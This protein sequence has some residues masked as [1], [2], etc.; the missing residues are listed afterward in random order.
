MILALL[1][2][3]PLAGW[4]ILALA[5]WRLPRPVVATV[6][7]ATVGAAFLVAAALARHPAVAGAGLREVWFD[8]I[9][10]GGVAVQAGAVYDRLSALMAQVVTGVGFLIH[11]YSAGYMADEAGYAR[12]FAALNLFVA[13]MLILVLGSSLLVLFVGW[14]LVGL[15]SYLL[16]GFWFDRER[17]A[18]A[19]RKA[20]LVNRI[21][22]AG[23]LLGVLVLATAGGTLE[24]AQMGA[25]AARLEPGLLAVITL[26]LFWGATGKSAQL[27]L[28]VWLPDAMEG[29]TPVSAL[30]HAAT[31]VTAGV[32]MIARL[33]P[34]FEAAPLTLD[35]VAAV[36]AVTALFAATAAL[37]EWDLKRVLAYST[38][39]QLGYMF[40]AMGTLAMPAGLLHLTTHAFFKAALF[41]A[42]GSVMHALGGVV[43]MRRLGGLAAPMR[44]TFLAFAS[45]ALALAGVPPFAGFVSKDLILE[46][47]YAHARAGGSVV[48]WVL[49]VL[50]AFVTA[51]YITRAAVY[52]FAPPASHHGH[53]H[54]PPASMTW[55]MGILAVLSAVGGLL[56]ARIAGAPLVR[57]LEDSFG[58]PHPEAPAG[59]WVAAAPVAVSLAGIAVALLAY[60][61]RREVSL[62]LLGRLCA[63]QW[64]VEAAYEAAVV[65]PARAAARALAVVDVRGIDGAVMALAGAVGRAGTGLRRLQTGFVRSYAAVLLVGAVLALGYWVLR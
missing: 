36:G 29:P 52:T 59:G 37:A 1:V 7:C 54:E 25:V 26:L 33:H 58:L 13:S 63:R 41:L 22:D 31:M 65:R 49:G 4:V 44:A 50:T 24:I 42:A 60:R 18:S 10:A 28:Y 19:G 32:Y 51:V 55:P 14:E 53:P 16:I 20:F 40:L 2:G 43:D 17:A 34:L 21:G 12:Y 56:G 9:V 5:G 27:P 61:G 30:I 35:V 46:H 8:W 47:A 45:G 64:Y 11:V 15:C 23:F 39:S 3:L 6:G 38:I 48:P 57:A 62:G